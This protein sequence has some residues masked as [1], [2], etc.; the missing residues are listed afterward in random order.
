MDWTWDWVSLLG[1]PILFTHRRNK[2]EGLAALF[3]Q[4]GQAGL[5]RELKKE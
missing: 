3:S 2:K 5:F 1:A 4:T